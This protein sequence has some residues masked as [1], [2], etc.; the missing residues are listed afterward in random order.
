MSQARNADEFL[1]RFRGIRKAYEDHIAPLVAKIREEYT[2]KPGEDLLDQTLEAHIRAFAV[3]ALLAALNWRLDARAEDGLPNLIPEA[4]VLSQRSGT[5]RFLDYLGLERETNNPLMIVET[6]RP[7][8]ELP[9]TRKPATSYSE[10]VSRGL[11]G[12]PL[13]GEWNDWLPDLR[14]YIRSVYAPGQKVPQRVVI[15]NGDWLIVFLDPSDAF[16]E[17]GSR[18]PS[19]IL[20]FL[21]RSDIEIR[22]EELF[23]YLE[24]GR[25]S[26]EMPPLAPRELPFYVEGTAVD[27][28]M[29]GLRL[30]YIEQR[31]IYKYSPVIKIAPILFIRS[32]YGTWLRVETPPDEYELPHESGRLEQHL[33]EVEQAAKH[34]LSEVNDCLGTSLQP[35]H[36]S[37]HYDSEEPFRALRGVVE[38]FKDEY[39][40]L[41]GDKT[42]YLLLTPSVLGCPYHVWAVCNSVSVASNPGPIMTRSLTSRSFFVSGELHHCAHRD[43]NSAKATQI[44]SANRPR[45]GPRS[46]QDGQAFCEIWRFERYLCCRTCVFEEVCTKATVFQLPCRREH[47]TN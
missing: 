2:G 44:T 11:A 46:G 3:N 19:R 32:R 23:R 33:Y 15:T 28:A 6:K 18:D 47:N 8:A 4:P 9:H 27:R 14:D 17:S 25:V 5:I 21:N 12:E 26:G 7:R 45:C 43:V 37:H 36:L 24:Y 38:C 40:V 31:G 13:K 16:L 20:A 29:H 10:V 41:T 39:L 22:Y 42:H 30:G 34:L 35:S 1:L